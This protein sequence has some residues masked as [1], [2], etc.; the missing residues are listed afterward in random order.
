[1][2]RTY[3]IKI[4]ELFDAQLNP[5]RRLDPAR[6]EVIMNFRRN[7]HISPAE[8]VSLLEETLSQW[9]ASQKFTRTLSEIRN[10]RSEREAVGILE[11]AMNFREL[12]GENL[13]YAKK[14]VKRIVRALRE[15]AEREAEKLNEQIKRMK[16]VEKTR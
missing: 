13:R 3:E 12:S 11:K 4:R 15:E 8:A 9:G 6:G 5:T 1:M 7:R 14:F 16:R 10:A 2:S